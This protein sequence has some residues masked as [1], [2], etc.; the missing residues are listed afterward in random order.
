MEDNEAADTRALANRVL[1]RVNADPD[2]DLAMLW[3]L[4]T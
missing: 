4:H 1:D 2:D 3:E